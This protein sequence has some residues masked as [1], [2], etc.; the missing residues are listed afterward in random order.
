MTMKKSACQFC[1]FM[2]LIAV[3][4]NAV[5]LT[6]CK[7]ALENKVCGITCTTADHSENVVFYKLPNTGSIVAQCVPDAGCFG[8]SQ[9]NI[10]QPDSVSTVLS[11]VH[12]REEAGEWRC[13]FGLTLVDLLVSWATYAQNV[14]TTMTSNTLVNTDIHVNATLECLHSA[15]DPTVTLQYENSYGTIDAISQTFE[16]TDTLVACTDVDFTTYACPVIIRAES[17]INHF[18]T[19]SIQLKTKV[20]NVNTEDVKTIATG[21]TFEHSTTTA[22]QQT[23]THETTTTDTTTDET[24]TTETNNGS[25]E[26]L[27]VIIIG[28]ILGACVLIGIIIIII[29]V[30]VKRRSNKRDYVNTTKQANSIKTLEPI[31]NKYDTPENMVMQHSNHWIMQ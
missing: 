19:Y 22:E 28:T 5:S 15:E 12:L 21:I 30:L 2:F 10:T 8:P 29:M 7:N 9:Y 14:S 13:V 3:D 11:F 1:V 25:K 27:I 24:T 6:S 20:F 31:V 18:D 26:N 4:V 23:T 16:C 17:G